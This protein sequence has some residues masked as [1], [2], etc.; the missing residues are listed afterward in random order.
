MSLMTSWSL[1]IVRC[2]GGSLYTG[3]T[4]D[5]D[6][7][8]EQHERGEGRGAKYLRGRGPLE[9]V[10]EHCVGDRGDA[11]RLEARI[12]KLSRPRKE[13]LVREADAID[14]MLF[15]ADQ[16]RPTGATARPRRS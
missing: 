13:D 11:L 10:V 14:E 7:R 12:K 6:R 15:H 16:P 8:F 4:T 3:V 9:L 5:V 1:Y 2:A